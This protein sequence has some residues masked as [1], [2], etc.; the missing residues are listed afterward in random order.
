MDHEPISL[1]SRM[2]VDKLEDRFELVNALGQGTA[3]TVYH[4][5]DKFRDNKEFALKILSN[6]MIFDKT[7]LSRFIDELKICSKINHPNIVQAFELVEGRD[8]IGYTMELVNGCDLRQ[9]LKTSKFSYAEVDQVMMQLL[10]GLSELHRLKIMHRDL[11][12][13]NIIMTADGVVKISDLGLVKKLEG[14]N[15]T[16]A[17]VLLG[18]PQYMAPEYIK[19]SWFDERSDIYSCGIILYELL[20]GKRRL[21]NKSGDDSIKH[22]MSTN[23]EI[24]TISV[25][26]EHAKYY[27]I[28]KYSLA[29]SPDNRFQTAKQMQTAFAKGEITFSKE[30][31]A[32][33]QKTKMRKQTKM[34]LHALIFV[35]AA[36]LAALQIYL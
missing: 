10:E 26:K 7:I 8:C 13:E 32:K 25:P 3:G 14:K 20:S 23:F 11:K 34:L 33:I 29:L 16:T 21:P 28:L 17:G 31:P 35:F 36:I 5:R 30:L 12:L 22:L 24:P 15:I 27:D 9:L 18:T 19:G 2:Q 4:V 6:K 1:Q